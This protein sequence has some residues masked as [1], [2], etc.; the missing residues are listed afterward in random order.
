MNL[1]YRHAKQQDLPALITLLAADALACIIH[2]DSAPRVI[3]AKQV[4]RSP[5]SRGYSYVT[6][7]IDK[8]APSGRI[9]SSSSSTAQ[10]PRQY[11]RR[12]IDTI[13]PGLPACF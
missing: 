6:K 11:K 3:I 9:R 13:E 5:S 8:K 12:C 2:E 7:M 4:G 10:T 1:K